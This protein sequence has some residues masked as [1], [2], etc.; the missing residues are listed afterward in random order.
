LSALD[1]LRAC[2]IAAILGLASPMIASAQ[3]DQDPASERST[4]FVAVEGPQAESVPG[5][6]L[7]VSAYGVAWLFLLLYVLRLGR[8]SARA[9]ADVARLEKSLGTTEKAGGDEPSS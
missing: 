4:E 8:L 5:G 9:Q 6:V 7:M 2:A 3:E 1:I